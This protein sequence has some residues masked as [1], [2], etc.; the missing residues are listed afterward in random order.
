M[1]EKWE[2]LGQMAVGGA[3]L[4]TGVGVARWKAWPVDLSVVTVFSILS[5]VGSWEE[6]FLFSMDLTVSQN[7]FE[8]VLQE[9]NFCLK[10]ASLGFSNC[11][12]IMVSSFPEQL[13]I[14]GAVR[15]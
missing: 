1:N 3:G 15:C 11:L 4:S 6:V 7:F 13:H 9:A 12:C 2:K 5:T 8:L 14:T 10:K